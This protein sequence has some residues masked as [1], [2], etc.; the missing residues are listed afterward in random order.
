MPKSNRFVCIDMEGVFFLCATMC[1]L[2]TM[3]SAVVSGM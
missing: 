1:I 2:A 3:N